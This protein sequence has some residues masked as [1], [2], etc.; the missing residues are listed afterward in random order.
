MWL[1]MNH[2]IMANS[3]VQQRTPGMYE[4]AYPSEFTLGF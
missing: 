4:A 3:Q 2:V 1:G